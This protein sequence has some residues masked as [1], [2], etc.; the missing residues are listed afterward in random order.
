MEVGTGVE[1]KVKGGSQWPVGTSDQK[2][3]SSLPK[4][5]VSDMA[6]YLPTSPGHDD[7]ES[8]VLPVHSTRPRG[9]L[10]D[11]RGVVHEYP[12][13]GPVESLFVRLTV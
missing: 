3:C 5:D 6:A 2:T 10:R 1:S 13:Q 9:G 8:L 12:G 7:H 11:P 4:S